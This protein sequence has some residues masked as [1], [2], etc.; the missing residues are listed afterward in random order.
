M[1][2][3]K[4]DNRFWNTRLHGLLI[5]KQNKLFETLHQKYGLH[6]LPDGS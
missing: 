4:V 3:L 1:A 6:T 5:L 2:L